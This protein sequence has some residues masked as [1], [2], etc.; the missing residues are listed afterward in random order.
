MRGSPSCSISALTIY[1]DNFESEAT[2]QLND[3]RLTRASKSVMEVFLFAQ[4]SS[5]MEQNSVSQFHSYVAHR[6]VDGSV[7]R[8][9]ICRPFSLIDHYALTQCLNEKHGLVILG[10]QRLW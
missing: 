4:P 1:H 2:N 7:L 5:K 9:H 6:D 10:R 3:G 8:H